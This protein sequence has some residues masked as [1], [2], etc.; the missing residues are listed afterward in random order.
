MLTEIFIINANHP[1]VLSFSSVPGPLSLNAAVFASVCF[2]S[3][4][5]TPWHAFATVTVAFELF[6]LWPVFSRKVKVSRI[7]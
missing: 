6:A 3:R 5:H 2:A 1:I 7:G 4:L